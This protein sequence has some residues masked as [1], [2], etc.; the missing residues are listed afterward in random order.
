MDMQY[1]DGHDDLAERVRFHFRNRIYDSGFTSKFEHG[2]MP[3]HF[4]LP[5]MKMGQQ[6][7]LFWSC[8]VDCP[9]N[10]FDFSNENY[11][12]GRCISTARHRSLTVVQ[13]SSTHLL[14]WMSYTA[15][16]PRTTTSFPLQRLTVLRP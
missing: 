14:R 16:S 6:G 8:W 4:D 15:C 11:A 1:T 9:K 3:E 12:P 7:G 10:G 2:G 5:R 13:W